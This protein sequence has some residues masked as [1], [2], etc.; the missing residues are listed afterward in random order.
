VVAGRDR[1]ELE[2]N[3][4]ATEAHGAT[5]EDGSPQISVQG[6]VHE[7]EVREGRE[8]EHHRRSGH[9]Q[10]RRPENQFR[11]LA[12]RRRRICRW[13]LRRRGPGS[14]RSRPATGGHGVDGRRGG[15][16][17]LLPSPDDE[18]AARGLAVRAAVAGTSY[19]SEIKVVYRHCSFL[20]MNYT[21]P[22][23]LEQLNTMLS[24]KCLI[25]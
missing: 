10:V 16:V 7:R 13:R 24:Q 5:F 19:S 1:D 25:N 6:V 11:R 15:S 14:G 2:H 18:L 4:E 8:E 9:A 12:W 23:N 17:N 20:T 22:H 21:G 3:E